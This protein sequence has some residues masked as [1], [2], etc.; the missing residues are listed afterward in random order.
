MTDEHDRPTPKQSLT[1]AEIAFAIA[2]GTPPR[3]FSEQ[4]EPEYTAYERWSA[5]VI[6]EEMRA[7]PTVEDVAARLGIHPSAVRRLV[8]GGG[9]MSATVDEVTVIPPWQLTGRGHLLPGLHEV[10][11]AMPGDYGPY[12]TQSI[13]TTPVE[14]LDGRSPAGA[15]EQG[16]PVPAIVD[17]VRWLGAGM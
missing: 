13:M 10:L 17:W 7:W 1:P 11:A 8:D 16:H 9:L 15:L 12:E 3:A 5:E 14:E 6:E 2:A 4:A